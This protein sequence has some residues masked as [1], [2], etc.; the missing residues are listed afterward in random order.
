MIAINTTCATILKRLCGGALFKRA[1]WASWVYVVLLAFSAVAQAQTQVSNFGPN[2]VIFDGEATSYAYRGSEWN[3]YFSTRNATP[4]SDDRMRVEVV[5]GSLRMTTPRPS[6]NVAGSFSINRSAFSQR[7]D[8]ESVSFS[9]LTTSGISGTFHADADAEIFTAPDRSPGNVSVTK[10]LPLLAPITLDFDGPG[11]DAIDGVF[12]TSSIFVSSGDETDVLGIEIHSITWRDVDS[13]A[14]VLAVETPVDPFT[15]DPTPSFTFTSTEAGTLDMGGSCGTSSGTDVVAGSNTITLTRTDG[16]AL[17]TPGG[18]EAQ[19]YSNCYIR[20]SDAVGNISNGLQIPAFNV[21]IGAPV[22]QAVLAERDII[23]GADA[24]VTFRLQFNEK[25][26][27]AETMQIGGTSG[28]AVPDIRVPVIVAGQTILATPDTSSVTTWDRRPTFTFKIPAGVVDSD[29]FE[30]GSAIQLNGGVIRDRAGNE[31]QNLAFPANNQLSRVFADSL[32][33]TLSISDA[34]GSE[35]DAGTAGLSYTVT[36]SAP[37]PQVAF[38][39]SYET[40]NGTAVAGDDYTAQSGTITIPAGA[41]SQTIDIP[42]LDDAISEGDETVI[43]TLTGVSATGVS[44]PGVSASVGDMDIGIADAEGVGTITDN[45]AVPDLVVS[46]PTVSEGDAGNSTLSFVVSLSGPVPTAG[47]TVDYATTGGSA[48]ASVDYQPASGQLTFAAGDVT[49]QVDITINGDEVVELDETFVLALSN[50]VGANLPAANPVGT[51]TNDDRATLTIDDVTVSE[52]DGTATVAIT[53]DKGVQDSFT[54]WL[55]SVNGTA[56]T[57]DG[58]YSVVANQPVLF[59]GVAGERKTLN[60]TLGNDTKVERDETF[61]LIFTSV[62]SAASAAI[63][64]SDT[65]TVTITND[66]RAVVTLVSADVN[67]NDGPARLLATLDVDVDG[68]F[69]VDLSTIDGSATLADGDY[70]RLVNEQLNFAGF[71]GENETYTVQIQADDTVEPDEDLSVVMG[72]L[73]PGRVAAGSID[74]T[75]TATVRLL[76]DDGGLLVSIDDPEITELDSGTSSLTFKVSLSEPA[77][78][79]GV[80][81]IYTTVAG[82]A[83]AGEDYEA[84]N[85][86]VAFA[87][88]EQEKD[89]EIVVKGDERVE[90]DET[91][92]LVLSDPSASVAVLLNDSEGTG[93]IRNNDSATIA[94]QTASTNLSEGDSGTIELVLD[95]PI[96]GGVVLGLEFRGRTAAASEDYVN[97]LQPSVSFAG[98]ADER[99][100]F[101]VTTIQDDVVEAQEQFEFLTTIWSLPEGINADAISIPSRDI[102]ILDDDTASLSIADVSG[103]ENAGAIT[104]AVRLDHKVDGGFEVDVATMDGTATVADADYQPVAAQTLTFLGN[105]GEEQTFTVAPTGDDIAELDETVTIA[106]ANLTPDVVPVDQIDIT[107]TGTLTIRNDDSLALSV[108]SPTVDE[109][110]S[111]S[112][113]LAFIVALSQPAPAGGINVDFGTSDGSA[114]AG[115]DYSA[116]NTTVRFAEGEDE[117]TV[118]VP[119]SADFRVEADETVNVRLRNP[120]GVGVP[121]DLVAEAT[122]T[123][124]NDDQAV[125]SFTDA[126]GGEDGGA[127]TVNAQLDAE[128]DGGLDIVLAS[129]DGSATLGDDDYS[130]LTG[131]VLSFVGT[132]NEVQSFTVVPTSD[133]RAEADESLTIRAD[134]VVPNSVE[135]SAIIVLGAANVTIVNDDLPILA[136]A[137]VAVT[138]EAGE[139]LV[140]VTLEGI[141][142]ETVAFTW[143]TQDGSAI[144]P[145]DYSAQS[146]IAANIPPGETN[147]TLRVPLVDDDTAESAEVFQIVLSNVTQA[148]AP[149]DPATVTIAASDRSGT[150]GSAAPRV[151]ALTRHAPEAEQTNAD[152]LVFGI[153]FSTTVVN[154]DPTDFLVNG[155]TAEATAVEPLPGTEY[156]VTVSG[157]DLATFNGIVGLALAE[158]TDITSRTGRALQGGLPTEAETYLLDSVAPTPGLSAQ[159]GPFPGPFEVTL[160][161]SE[162]VVGMTLEGLQITNGTV[163]ALRSADNA[164]FTFTVSPEDDG[165]V[166]IDLP[167]DATTDLAGNNSTAAPSLVRVVDRQA[168]SVSLQSASVEGPGRWTV[169]ARFS[170]A[171]TGFDLTD[172][173]VAGGTASDLRAITDREFS[174]RITADPVPAGDMAGDVTISVP[175]EVAQDAAGNGNHAAAPLILTPDTDPPMAQLALPSGPVGRDFV[176]ELMFE[177]E[178]RIDLAG[179]TVTQSSVRNLRPAGGA[180]SARRAAASGDNVP[181]TAPPGVVSDH[182]LVDVTL[183]PEVTS[184]TTVEVV[185]DNAYVSDLSGNIGAGMVRAS[186]LADVDHP[187]LTLSGPTERVM[188]PFKVEVSASEDIIGLTLDDFEVENATIAALTRHSGAS[189]VVTV[190]PKQ[191]AGVA[192]TLPAGSVTDAALN[193]NLAP[194]R[195]AVQMQSPETAFAERRDEI[196]DVV[197]RDAQRRLSN[198][199]RANASMMNQRLDRFIASFGKDHDA[200]RGVP[201]DVTGEVTLSRDRPLDTRGTFFGERALHSGVIRSVSGRFDIAMDED[202]SWNALI[203]GRVT[204]EHV[205]SKDTR[206]GYFLGANVSRGQIDGGFD[207]DSNSIGA[208]IGGYGITRLSE[209]LFANAYLG[210]GYSRTDL[211]FADETLALKSDY[212]AFSYY[213]GLSVVGSHVFDTGVELRPQLRMDYG[214]SEIGAI[215]FQADA[216]G[217]SSQISQDIGAVSVLDLAFAPEFIF[218]FRVGTGAAKFHLRP[219]LVCSWTTGRVS[220]KACGAGLGVALDGHSQNEQVTYGLSLEMRDVGDL[221]GASLQAFYEARF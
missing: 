89:I 170:E 168:P 187:E 45:E 215:V 205:I 74:I 119:V 93:T 121:S 126:S 101:A 103:D 155:S 191:G 76:N 63:D 79:G 133:T 148:I 190:T 50:A 169:T 206:L 166:T 216:F 95:R 107:Q 113:M 47:V 60:I 68:G 159:A 180:T 36:L 181:M 114:R 14:P 92:T 146:G 94:I 145:E 141:T 27:F 56:S 3:V 91:L 199:I 197:Q 70:T 37:A 208:V 86:T 213:G 177:E 98:T 87:A 123:I 212:G 12:F 66:D 186:A 130:D 54:T 83:T 194:A 4:D 59:A 129:I 137:D 134:Q 220:E 105:A 144:A 203:S 218:P 118:E 65:A 61:D 153:R 210:L 182:W 7:F 28:V 158:A 67:E 9:I 198:E 16:S 71:A 18:T 52:A 25:I 109:G 53:L 193:P 32:A 140:D 96:Q 30:L 55:S 151:I 35:A 172:L 10:S 183:G 49:K 179:I 29:G 115:E 207:G 1:A 209:R 196:V 116:T 20:V 38:D 221:A 102:N 81:V 73:A 13:V 139:A 57:D 122:G 211:S 108:N 143:S 135:P 33:R 173:Q 77:P 44:A 219:E 188:G 31:I 167:A 78:V 128:V 26:G 42:I 34:T 8:I 19:R 150:G 21:D 11:F 111:G 41:T 88:G 195:F 62:Q 154:V 72:N 175:A 117:K 174:V 152:T 164:S 24:T 124:V 189:Y 149:D 178:V 165:D 147:V 2:T 39:V 64:A 85:S 99:H 69:S 5:N 157:G 192:L 161:F 132:A 6:G 100:S 58:D 136:I 104:V 84:I 112:A 200:S 23:H 138:E 125:V 131:Q 156:A 110:S 142:D 46:S 176:L 17:V 90:A 40:S 185:I 184:D 43:L 214:R 204:Y 163:D 201:F 120:T 171:V 202:D 82:T 97:D 15:T 48:T 22:M 162:P 51:I 75:S 127:I 160:R 106:L 217:L 80:R